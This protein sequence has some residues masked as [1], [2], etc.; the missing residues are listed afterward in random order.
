MVVAGRQIARDLKD[1]LLDYVIVVENPLRR[2][3][4][5]VTALDGSCNRSI[6]L[7]QCRFV[8]TKSPCESMPTDPGTTAGLDRGQGSR[9]LFQPLGTKLLRADKLFV[10]PEPC[11]TALPQEFD[12]ATRVQRLCSLVGCAAVK[13]W[14][15]AT[16][17]WWGI[18]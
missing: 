7:Q 6:R 16:E 11:V 10:V 9:V 17:G 15:L 4:D 14:R 18:Q 13:T 3:C 1:L 2:G 12:S 5:G 8:V